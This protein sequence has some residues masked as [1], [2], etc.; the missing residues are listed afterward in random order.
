M[1]I[2][3]LYAIL[4]FI[5]SIPVDEL[6]MEHF[7][8]VADANQEEYCHQGF[9]GCVIGHAVRRKVLPE[10]DFNSLGGI[11]FKTPTQ[12]HKANIDCLVQYLDISKENLLRIFFEPESKYE[13]K[14]RLKAFLLERVSAT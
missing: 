4:E 13:V 6:D 1:N 7:S 8:N 11:T 9:K 3:P 5:D 14:E 12:W 10:L 2:K